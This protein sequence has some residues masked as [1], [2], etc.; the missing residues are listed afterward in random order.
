MIVFRKSFQMKE[1]DF[2]P[3]AFG[4][5]SVKHWYLMDFTSWAVQEMHVLLV[6]FPEAES[7]LTAV[8]RPFNL[9]VLL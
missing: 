3:V 1:V 8:I 4:A 6:P 7:R 9:I 2:S 5:V